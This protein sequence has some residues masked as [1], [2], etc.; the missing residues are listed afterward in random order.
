VKVIFQRYFEI[1]F[2]ITA[3]V[4]LALMNPGTDIHYSFC[5]FKLMGIHFCPGCGI[6]HSISFLFHGNINASLSAHPLGIFA[7]AVITF[8]IY[9]LFSLHFLSTSKNNIY[10]I[11]QQS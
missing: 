5:I 6:G 8:R 9:K 3:L 2:W 7:L 4:L 11:R 10:G 1:A